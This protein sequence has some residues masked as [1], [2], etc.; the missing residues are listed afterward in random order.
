MDYTKLNPR[1][2]MIH[3][4]NVIWTARSPEQLDACKKMFDNYKKQ[5][6]DENIGVTFIEV[7]LSRQTRL[8]EL[9][10]KMGKVQE[11]LQ[12]E[13]AEKA[14]K[15]MQDDFNSQLKAANV[16]S[17][18]KVKPIKSHKP[19]NKQVKEIINSP[20]AKRIEKEMTEKFKNG[21]L[22]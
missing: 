3:I 22:K 2:Q 5:N 19:I 18:P 12:K 8:N 9:F 14:Q 7:E 6:G 15:Q 10:A 21:E 17:D 4:I 13:N 11:A 16:G 20:R 1:D